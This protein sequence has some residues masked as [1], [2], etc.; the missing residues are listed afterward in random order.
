M[1]TQTPTI[2]A[3]LVVY[4]EERVIEQCL[5]SISGLVDEIIIVHDGECTDKTLDIARQYTDRIFVR[6]H[7][8]EAEP[9]RAFSFS[10]ATGEWILQIDADEFLDTDSHANIARTLAEAAEVDGFILKWELWDGS[11]VVYFPGLEKMCFFRKKNFHFVGIPHEAGTV[12]G[13]IER[14]PITMHHRPAY[15]NIAWKSFLKKRAKW[16]PV[17]AKY[18][19]PETCRYECFNT[20]ADAWIQH[21]YKV[22]KIIGRY[23]IFE[24]LKMLI[25]QLKNGLILSKAGIQTALQQYVYY[26]TLYW[27]IRKQDRLKK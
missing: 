16:V 17:H 5:R 6:D 9:H 8:G 27:E 26:L 13:K 1:N 18:F 3:C 25:G 10:Q 7:I 19:F 11:R 14:I 20:T 2:S 23:I 21:A 4:N 12:D 22:R 24:P 15:N